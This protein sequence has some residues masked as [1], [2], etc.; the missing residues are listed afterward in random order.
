[1]NRYALIIL[2]TVLGCSPSKNDYSPIPGHSSDGTTSSPSAP[3][4]PQPRGNT[5]GNGG[6]F[7]ESLFEQ[8]RIYAINILTRVRR[9]GFPSF[10]NGYLK[11]GEIDWM[12]GHQNKIAEEVARSRFHWTLDDLFPETL[13][14]WKCPKEACACTPPPPAM[15]TYFSRIHCNGKRNRSEVGAIITQ[16]TLHRFEEV[17]DNEDKAYRIATA[18][19]SIW[20]NMGHSDN[21]HWE[22]MN[23]KAG[24]PVYFREINED[25][26]EVFFDRNRQVAWTGKEMLVWDPSGSRS[27]RILTPSH[28]KKNIIYSYSPTEDFW[29]EIATLNPYDWEFRLLFSYEDGGFLHEEYEKFRSAWV[30][31]KWLFFTDCPSNVFGS[32]IG[33]L[34]YN[35][36]SN[37][38]N[39]LPKNQERERVITKVIPTR[40]GV[41]LW[42]GIDCVDYMTELS[43][44]SYYDTLS[45]KWLKIPPP[46]E[47]FE[48]SHRTG[49]SI[50]W[51]DGFLILWGGNQWQGDRDRVNKYFDS[52]AVYDFGEK[53]WKSIPT[54]GR[55]PSARS[56]HQAV[57]MGD[58]LLIFGGHSRRPETPGPRIDRNIFSPYMAEDFGVYDPKLNRWEFVL[59]NGPPQS[60]YYGDVNSVWTG[61]EVI[62]RSKTLMRFDPFSKSWISIGNS[63]N[64]RQG[65]REFSFWSG[66]DWLVWN[67]DSGEGNRFFP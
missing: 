1:M 47:E 4:A 57:V 33:G 5:V 42:G 58:K 44:G 30:N 6:D 34:S 27:N 53:E 15:D 60:F 2:F 50:T 52:G 51:I 40:D 17:G 46:P 26:R 55:A 9:E 13:K 14:E 37:E 12:F 66:I 63:P 29:K 36:K 16:T 3:L 22:I 21:P 19:F 8:G 49:M 41:I 61:L 31:G 65:L 67:L 25:G 48:L 11:A 24:P 35:L 54:S 28:I 62:S 45:G 39:V 56:G 7:L 59:A 20:T 18:F 38:W 43:G 10:L 64:I 23:D 32:D